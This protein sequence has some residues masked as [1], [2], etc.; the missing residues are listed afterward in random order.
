MENVGCYG[1]NGVWGTVGG[2]E[3]NDGLWN[4]GGLQNA[5]GLKM[6]INNMELNCGANF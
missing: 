5:E 6:K 4:Y 2:N 3:C 1:I